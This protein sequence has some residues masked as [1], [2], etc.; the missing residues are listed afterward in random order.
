VDEDFEWRFQLREQLEAVAGVDLQW[1][2]AVNER[3]QAR[4]GALFAQL[5][6]L[7]STGWLTDEDLTR[8]EVMLLCIH[9]LQQQ[10]LIALDFK[11][12]SPI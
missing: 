7:A 5:I 12:L 8:P 4:S 1:C 10:H 2:E 6:P 9:D 3:L 11:P